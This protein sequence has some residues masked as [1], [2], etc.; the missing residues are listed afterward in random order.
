MIHKQKFSKKFY[1]RLT[2]NYLKNHQH[3]KVF[4][5]E[6]LLINF[7]GKTLSIG[8]SFV[9]LQYPKAQSILVDLFTK[10]QISN[11][12]HDTDSR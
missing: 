12:Q 7:I 5:N 6:N 2:I 10:T 11:N 8:Q 3:W 9:V 1:N 4:Q